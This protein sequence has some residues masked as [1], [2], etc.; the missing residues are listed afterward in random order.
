MLSKNKRIALVLAALLA[1]AGAIG[2]FAW[3]RSSAGAQAAHNA[4]EY[5]CPMH[6]TI[7]RDKP[8]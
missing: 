3:Y 7:V 1:G 2:L 5:F 4:A 6:P 8:G